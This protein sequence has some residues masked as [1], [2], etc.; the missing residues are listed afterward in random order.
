VATVSVSLRVTHNDLDAVARGI[1]WLASAWPYN[2]ATLQE[3]HHQQEAP[4]GQEFYRDLDGNWHPGWLR[5]SVDTTE[6]PDGGQLT[7]VWAVYGIYVNNGTRFMAANPFW[8]RATLRT[9]REA[10]GLTDRLTR[11]MLARAVGSGSLR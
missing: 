2:M 5:E 8:E 1:D 6:L 11:Q 3:A 10:D 4:L 9:E 7:T